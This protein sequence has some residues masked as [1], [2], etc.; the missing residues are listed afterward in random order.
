MCQ[1]PG[2][3]THCKSQ[4]P[5][6]PL[7]LN[8]CRTLL[9]CIALLIFISQVTFPRQQVTKKLVKF[10]QGKGG[11]HSSGVQLLCLWS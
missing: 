2:F 4:A 11:L 10:I 5:L 1:S 9:T 8:C 3:D 7:S 6:G